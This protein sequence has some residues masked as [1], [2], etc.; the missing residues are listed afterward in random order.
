MLLQ[1]PPQLWRTK[2]LH[3]GGRRQE[4]QLSAPK[5]T[6]RIVTLSKP[7]HPAL[8]SSIAREFSFPDRSATCLIKSAKIKI[9]FEATEYNFPNQVSVNLAHILHKKLFAYADCTDLL[10]TQTG[11]DV[12]EYQGD[13]LPT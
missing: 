4:W 5:G 12:L 9:Y 11:Q 1:T 10:C 8:S 2:C 7:E 3:P 13:L 6:G